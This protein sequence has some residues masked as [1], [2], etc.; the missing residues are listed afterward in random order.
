MNVCIAARERGV[1]LR[2]LGDV[3]VVMP[4]LSI[5]CEEITHIV[6]AIAYGIR[7]VCHAQSPEEPDA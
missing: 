2:P 7:S 1:F 4:P 5:T 6:D 3:I